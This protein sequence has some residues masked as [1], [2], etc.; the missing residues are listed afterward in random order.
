M[1]YTASVL[2]ISDKGSRGERVDKSGPALVEALTTAGYTVIHTEIIPDEFDIIAK[3]L[4]N[5]CDELGANLIL[6]T[7]GTGFSPRDITPEATQS[8]IERSTPGLVEYTR[9]E[10]LKITPKAALSRAAAGIRGKSLII[11]MPGSPKAAT[12]HIGFLLPIL[13]HGLDILLELDGECARP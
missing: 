6:T 1:A 7:G 9:Q 3:A 2:T 4:T 8:V 12:E 11:N 13:G 5:S 10:S